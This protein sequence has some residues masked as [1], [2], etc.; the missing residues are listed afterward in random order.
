[1]DKI[2][3]V[4]T[5]AREDALAPWITPSI[6]RLRRLFGVRIWLLNACD[7]GSIT[8]TIIADL[9]PGRVV[10]ERR[11]PRLAICQRLP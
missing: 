10:L 5:P 4:S 7:D 2:A 9:V 3:N 1:M 6:Q 8:L 11:P